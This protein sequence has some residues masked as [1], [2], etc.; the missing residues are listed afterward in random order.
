VLVL[1]VK[2]IGSS[3]GKVLFVACLG[4]RIRCDVNIFLLIR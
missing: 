3:I 2:K 1:W 4:R